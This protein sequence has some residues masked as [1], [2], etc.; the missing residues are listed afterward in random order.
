MNQEVTILNGVLNNVPHKE[1][2]NYIIENAMV[3][4]MMLMVA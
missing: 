2:Q 1:H 3:I 4:K